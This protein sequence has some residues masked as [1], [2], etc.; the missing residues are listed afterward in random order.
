MAA[1]SGS[2]NMWKVLFFRLYNLVVC[3]ALG[4]CYVRLLSY[5]MNK[6]LLTFGNLFEPFH[7]ILLT[8]TSAFVASTFII[9][10]NNFVTRQNSIYVAIASST[11]AFCYWYIV[12]SE[13][14]VLVHIFMAVTT[15]YSLFA[16]MAFLG[17][18]IVVGIALNNS[19][20]KDAQR[21]RSSA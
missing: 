1:L 15:P 17:F 9:I 3:L 2:T 19:R 14:S 4:A 18:P 8:G 20:Q 21:A 13:Y 11:M 10:G 16:M 6:Y 5:I 12:K 7:R